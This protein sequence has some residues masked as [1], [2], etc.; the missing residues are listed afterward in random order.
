[1]TRRMQLFFVTALA[2]LALAST[3]AD[4]GLKIGVVDMDQALSATDEGKSAREELGRK[5][6]EARGQVEPMV[7]RFQALQEEVKG[8]KYVL[9]EEALFEKQVE[10]A[11]LKNKIENKM[12]ELEGQLQIDQGRIVA[13]LRA[14]MLEIIEGIGKEQGYTLILERGTPG[15]IY[16]REALDITDI[17]IGR[18]N[19]KG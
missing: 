5:E 14:K 19:K 9:S 4:D 18:F 7:E 6:R 3:G 1:M 16:T 10:L 8:K 13:P 17:V 11:E 2:V 12:K 15:V